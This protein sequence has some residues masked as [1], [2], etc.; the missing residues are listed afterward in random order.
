MYDIKFMAFALRYISYSDIGFASTADLILRRF[1]FICLL[2]QHAMI[3]IS[4]LHA[5]CIG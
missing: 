5:I 1:D 2:I 3:D 4:N